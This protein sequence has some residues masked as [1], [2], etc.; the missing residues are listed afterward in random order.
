[1]DY[2]KASQ[3]LDKV[4]SVRYRNAHKPELQGVIDRLRHLAFARMEKLDKQQAGIYKDVSGQPDPDLGPVLTNKVRLMR[5]I[6][7]RSHD[8]KR[9]LNR[10]SSRLFKSLIT[11]SNPTDLEALKSHSDTLGSMESKPVDNPFKNIKRKDSDTYHLTANNGSE[12]ELKRTPRKGYDSWDLTHLESGKRVGDFESS[13]SGH[14]MTGSFIDAKEHKGKG[15]GNLAYM[16]MAQHYGSIESDPGITLFPGRKL[17]MSLKKKGLANVEPITGPQRKTSSKR[18]KYAGKDEYSDRERLAAGFNV[19]PGDQRYRL[20]MHP[21]VERN[22]QKLKSI[23]NPQKY[24]AA[25][26]WDRSEL[27]A[28]ARTTREGARPETERA[29]EYKSKV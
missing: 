23:R 1:M 6:L 7:Q 4:A 12:Y 16:A 20:F 25:P 15:L 21:K 3:V 2:R 18:W 9:P 27:G 17:W 22:V 5:D 14:E 13:G 24:P 8:L 19:L 10:R 26:K 29:I 11:T 28:L